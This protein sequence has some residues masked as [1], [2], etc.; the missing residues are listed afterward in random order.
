[1]FFIQSLANCKEIE[2][3]ARAEEI[4]EI[5]GVVFSRMCPVAGKT[6]LLKKI[7]LSFADSYLLF[8][9]LQ[10]SCTTGLLLDFLL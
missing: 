5:K 8:M 2:T 6:I 10:K 1:M 3:L 9:N 4:G 7:L